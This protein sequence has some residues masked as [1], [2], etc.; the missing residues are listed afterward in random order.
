MGLFIKLCIGLLIIGIQVLIG[1]RAFFPDIFVEKDNHALEEIMDVKKPILDRLSPEDLEFIANN[2]TINVG[3]DSNFYPIEMFDERG[4]YSGLGAD[5][6]KLI[7]YL[8]DLEF[9]PIALTDW[10]ATEESA[11][12]GKVQLLPA[13]AKTGRRSEFLLFTAPYISL[14]GIIMTRRDNE[15]EIKGL[16][17]LAGKKLAVTRGYAWHDFLREFHPEIIA[18]PVSNTL[19]ALRLVSNGEADAVLDY[20]FNLLEKMRTAGIMQLQKSA[21]VNSNYGHAVGVRNDQPELFDIVSIAMAQI[22]PEEHK[23]LAMKWLQTDQAKPENK[24]LQWIFFFLLEAVLL[25][26]GLNYLVNRKVA[27]AVKLAVNQK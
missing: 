16:E 25:C 26:L 24:Q 22:T 21:E 4:R 7:S 20:E 3:V 23:K 12:Q 19:E 2:R 9:N 8:A 11:R 17:D 27:R 15:E 18:V 1:A 5:Y 10:A 13:A 14:P 6:L